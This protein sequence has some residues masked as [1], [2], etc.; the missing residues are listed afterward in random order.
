LETEL[1]W[2]TTKIRRDTDLIDAAEE[3]LDDKQI[4]WSRGVLNYFLIMLEKM[5]DQLYFEEHRLEMLAWK[6]HEAREG[7]PPELFPI[8]T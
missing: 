1:V 8:E 7:R 5:K 4:Y 6:I 2:L 3:F